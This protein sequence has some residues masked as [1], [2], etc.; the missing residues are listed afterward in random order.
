M[1]AT[2]VVTGAAGDIG[3]A[4]VE[5]LLGD[6]YAVE[7]WDRDASRLAEND[8]AFADQGYASRCVD[9]LD[10]SAVA[11]ASAAARDY[12]VRLLVN[13]AGGVTDA[14]TLKT[15]GEADFQRDLD[16]NLTAAWRCLDR[17]R[18]DLSGGG[19][20][21]NV[22]SINGMGVYGFPGYSAAKAGLLHLT[23]F[24]AVEL[25]KMGIRVN[26][27]APGTVRTKA[28][29]SRLEN[30]PAL[31]DKIADWYPLKRICEPADVAAAVA[32]LAGDD[33]RMITGVALPVDGGLT[34]GLDRLASDLCQAE[35]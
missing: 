33:A 3:R 9:L 12:P 5:R 35:I 26:A 8:A 4:I 14:V 30:D 22:A 28:W 18:N 21:V 1:D 31:F 15:A 29:D 2:A 24:A 20:V 17:L 11:D 10:M 16:L 6:G 19:A 23:R 7:G 27:V 25:G 13:N 32:F 34:A